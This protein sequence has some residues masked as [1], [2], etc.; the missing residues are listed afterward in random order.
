MCEAAAEGRIILRVLPDDLISAAP[1]FLR[2]KGRLYHEREQ[3]ND[4]GRDAGVR[5]CLWLRREASAIERPAQAHWPRSDRDRHRNRPRCRDNS[6]DDRR[7]LW[8]RPDVA[9]LPHH[10]HGHHLYDGH[11]PSGHRDRD[12]DHPRHPQVLRPG[13]FRHRGLRHVP[14]L[15]VLHDGQHLRHR[16]RYEPHLRHR[17]E[18]RLRHHDRGRGV[19]VL[20][21]ERLFQ[22]RKDHYP[23]HR[24]DDRGVLCHAG[25]CRRPGTSGACQRPVR[26]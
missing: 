15:P 24:P 21:Q 3:C 1:S 22:G 26:L 14:F 9:V 2:I 18:D 8:L 7:K 16:C 13:G 5:S 12:A 6:L 23:L 20:C 19:Y 25:G 11:Q 4:V 17:L 10:F